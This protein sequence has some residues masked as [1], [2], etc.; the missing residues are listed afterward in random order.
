MSDAG[1]LLRLTACERRFLLLM[2]VEWI[3]HDN[4][5]QYVNVATDETATVDALLR[6]LTTGEA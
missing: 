2:V 5:E 3:R 1:A 4:P 6:K